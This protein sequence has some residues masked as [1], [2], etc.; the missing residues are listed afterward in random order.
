M[1]KDTIDI[2]KN[3]PDRWVGETHFELLPEPQPAKKVKKVDRRG[4]KRK[5]EKEIGGH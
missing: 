3:L 1:I 2:I 5:A 4:A